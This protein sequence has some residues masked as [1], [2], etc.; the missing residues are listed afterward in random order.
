[1]KIGNIY[2][3]SHDK[4][5]S[6]ELHKILIKYGH[7]DNPIWKKCNE[8]SVYKEN[9]IGVHVRRT[10]HFLHGE[11][12]DNEL[13]FRVIDSKLK[14][15]NYRN[16]LLI[17]D[18]HQVVEEFVSNYGDM[19]LLNKNI[20]RSED[21]NAIH[22]KYLE[23]LDSLAQEIMIESISL[24]RCEEIIISSSKGSGYSLMLNPQIKFEQ[25]D[26]HINYYDY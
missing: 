16:I 22:Y 1:M 24:S 13:Y 11:F 26:R 23:N 21:K 10:D 19:I 18:E 4:N 14:D 9:T 25:I 6:E 12:L 7:F 3:F 15:N 8:E 17:T 20:Y 5:L 2:S